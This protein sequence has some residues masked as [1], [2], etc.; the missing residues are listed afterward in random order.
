MYTQIRFVNH[1]ILHL[2]LYY[3]E[4]PHSVSTCVVSAVE[5][6]WACMDVKQLQ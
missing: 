3:Q 1:E 2:V 5:S 4:V 6:M